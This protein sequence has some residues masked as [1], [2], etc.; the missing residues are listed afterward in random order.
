MMD[1]LYRRLLRL[2]PREYDEADRVEMWETYRARVAGAHG[3]GGGTAATRERLREALDLVA[4]L[5]RLRWP[6]PS[7]DSLR[8]DVRVGVRSLR[9]SPLTSTLAVVSLALGLGATTA[10]FS[11]LDVWL[12]RPIPLPNEDRLV[13]VGMANLE[14][15]WNFNAFS[16]RDYV[17]W[18]SRTESV[19]LGIYARAGYNMAAGDRAERVSALSVSAN[20]P[21]ILGIDVFRGRSLTDEDGAPGAPRVALI[22]HAFWRS[23]LGADP[24]VIGKELSLDG[25]PH[26]VIGV[27][28]P[29]QRIPDEPAA[30][31]RPLRISGSESRSG[32]SY[33]AIALLDEGT[34]RAAAAAELDAI[35]GQV[36]ELDPA[37]TFPDAA[38]R[39]YREVVYTPELR[40]VA[41]VLG[42]AALFVLLIACSN[43]AHILLA[44]GVARSH[45]I[46]VRGALGAGRMRVLQQ[47]LVE[48]LMIAAVGGALGLGLAHVGLDLLRTYALAPQV[49]GWAT[50]SIDGRILTVAAGLTLASTLAF[51]LLPALR[52]SRVD[53]RG[54]LSEGG[55]DA[56]VG[57]RSRLGSAFV[58]AEVSASLVLLALSGLMIRAIVEM[59]SVDL[60]TS[61]DDAVTFRI[62]VPPASQESGDEL[63]RF[64]ADLAERLRA[65]PG[66]TGVTHSSGHFLRRW[67]TVLYAIPGLAS[68]D[69]RSRLSAEYRGVSYSYADVVGLDLV[70]GRWFD[71][72]LDGAEGPDV[73]VVSRELTD[74]WWST[75]A[76]AVGQLVV[77]RS[78]TELQ[79]VGVVEGM[80]IRGP[81]R[82]PPPSIFELSAQRPTRYQFWLVRHESE[83]ETVA[84]RIRTIVREMDPDLAV[85]SLYAGR[86][87]M[88]DVLGEQYAGL[89]IFGALGA[90]ALLLTLVGVYGVVAHSV[91]R[92]LPEMGLRMA[93]GANPGELVRTVVRQSARTAAIGLGLGVLVSL[94]AG[95]G[96]AWLL[97]G[98][99]PRDPVVLTGVTVLL[100]LAILAASAVPATRAA[101]VDPVCTLRRG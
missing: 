60:G 59:R 9:R 74:L 49:P 77:P 42:V 99:S 101:R 84:G 83:P 62:A 88:E 93:L 72:A 2:L 50:M 29:D 89:R 12:V 31:W 3:S 67:S 68:L 65:E 27:M 63:R 28:H 51:G 44:R 91:G 94:G 26:T 66:V 85:F 36:A 100:F 79:I 52:T 37:S 95:Q 16:I 10:L 56:G 38:V 54:R 21:G 34:G 64:H 45:E 1:R 90:L 11:A 24:D 76:E 80:R 23:T 20:L 19:T 25:V 18:S 82:P 8:Q 97:L 47:L 70:A 73:A 4:T 33:R 96:L 17:D 13:A 48:S 46:A 43:I 41:I 98:V 14:R 61:F 75:P 69:E 81:G 87:V 30:I 22:T 55:R 86:E 15:G 58:V 7:T 78:D 71:E 39:P 53:L 40:Q 5:V 6:L 57:R 35:A 92:R 32:H